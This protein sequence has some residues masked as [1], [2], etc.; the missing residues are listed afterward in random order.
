V[1]CS[2]I[3]RLMLRRVT[4]FIQQHFFYTCFR[5]YTVTSLLHRGSELPMVLTCKTAAEG[6]SLYYRVAAIKGKKKGRGMRQSGLQG[7]R[8]SREFF[9][10]N[11]SICHF[12]VNMG[13]T[14]QGPAERRRA[15]EYAAK[16]GTMK[17]RTEGGRRGGVPTLISSEL[18]YPYLV[19][20]LSYSSIVYLASSFQYIVGSNTCAGMAARPARGSICEVWQ[21]DCTCQAQPTFLCKSTT[22]RWQQSH[23]PY[24]TQL[25]TNILLC[26]ARCNCQQINLIPVHAWSGVATQ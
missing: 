18:A 1:L 11:L 23:M 6:R 12:A 24:P 25:A 3:V 13:L 17:S 10:Q 20:I 14:M 7:I 26:A 8:S 16:V 4:G 9:F 15:S 19:I 5:R 2:R 21:F 22:P